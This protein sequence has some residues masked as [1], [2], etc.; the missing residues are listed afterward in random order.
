MGDLQRMLIE[1]QYCH[2]LDHLDA[3]GSAGIFTED[4]MHKSAALPAPVHSR[5]AVYAWIQA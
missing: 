1:P 4:G 2:R 3:E 5:S